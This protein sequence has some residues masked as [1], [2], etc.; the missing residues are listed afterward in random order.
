MWAAFFPTQNVG[1]FCV[2]WSTPFQTHPPTTI[3]TRNTTRKVSIYGRR[4]A[5]ARKITMGAWDDGQLGLAM[6]AHL[7]KM[8]HLGIQDSYT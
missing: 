3:T 5:A 7:S 2:M 1:T 8:G 4:N 6:L